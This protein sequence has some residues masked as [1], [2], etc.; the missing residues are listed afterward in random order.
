[1][2]NK[3]IEIQNPQ[4]IEG[5]RYTTCEELASMDIPS[6]EWLAF[7]FI[8][9]GGF[10]EICGDPGDYKSWIM[11]CL[12]IQM[13][14]GWPAFLDRYELKPARI[15]YIDFEMG[16]GVLKEREQLLLN[17]MNIKEHPK[18]LAFITEEDMGEDF[19]FDLLSE[20]T[21]KALEQ[22]I[23]SFNATHPTPEDLVLVL[24]PFFDASSARLSNEDDVGKLKRY[25][26]KLKRKFGLTLQ[27]LHH[28]RKSQTD[29][30]QSSDAH[31]SYGNVQI[32]GKVDTMV[33]VSANNDS[34]ITISFPKLKNC[35][36]QQAI[37]VK[38]CTDN[39]KPKESTKLWFE[40]A[41]VHIPKGTKL[42][43]DDLVIQ[44]F[45]SHGK[46]KVS[47]DELIKRSDEL[48]CYGWDTLRDR[49]L[50]TKRYIAVK[51]GKET[52]IQ[53]V[54]DVKEVSENE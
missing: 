23:K 18:N 53:R 31:N 41:G 48:K 32:F 12:S 15:L 54:I 11:L 6:V 24:D 33:S 20:K 22:T 39:P 51:E 7:P 47:R 30:F 19:D 49:L 38:V 36:R 1:M 27:I 28:K 8:Q 42:K 2:D 44:V 50:A 5:F 9:K 46:D 14:T 3:A 21:Q 26:M 29:S 4:V 10:C 52:Y 34:E 43:S 37:I 13:A 17:G 25:L 40:Y 16:R 45:E 35:P